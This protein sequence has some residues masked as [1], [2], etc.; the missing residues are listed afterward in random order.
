M[1]STYLLLSYSLITFLAAFFTTFYHL[2]SWS[3]SVNKPYR[4]QNQS[5]RLYPL[6]NNIEIFLSP[7]GNKV[8]KDNLFELIANNFNCIFHH[9]AKGTSRIKSNDSICVDKDYIYDYQHTF[10]KELSLNLIPESYQIYQQDINEL[11]YGLLG[12]FV[13]LLQPIQ[14]QISLKNIGWGVKFNTFGVQVDYAALKNF[15]NLFQK[16]KVKVN[17]QVVLKAKIEIS[18]F[19]AEADELSFRDAKTILT[20][21]KDLGEYGFRNPMIYMEKNSEPL[22]LSFYILLK[23]DKQHKL[24]AEIPN[25]KTNLMSSNFKLSFKYDGVLLPPIR[26]N[27]SSNCTMS[28][29]TVEYKFKDEQEI[30]AIIN[31]K[32]DMISKVITNSVHHFLQENSDIIYQYE[33]QIAELPRFIEQD[34]KIVVSDFIDKQPTDMDHVLWKN[35]LTDLKQSPEFLSFHISSNFCEPYK[36]KNNTVAYSCENPLVPAKPTSKVVKQ[37]AHLPVALNDFDV[38]LSVD[39]ALFN[40]T[41]QA[42]YNMKTFN[43]IE[44]SSDCETKHLNEV[45][46]YQKFLSIDCSDKEKNPF[47]FAIESGDLIDA[48]PNI[49]K[50]NNTKNN[51]TKPIYYYLPNEVETQYT[52]LELRKLYLKFIEFQSLKAKKSKKKKN[53]QKISFTKAPKISFIQEPPD[54]YKMLLLSGIS[55]DPQ[56]IAKLAQDPTRFRINVSVDFFSKGWLQKLFLARKI[57]INMDLIARIQMLP[58]QRD[59]NGT[60]PEGLAL[61]IE[62]VDL[63]S[64]KI[65]S[66]DIRWSGKLISAKTKIKKEFIDANK[67]SLQALLEGKPIR[68][69]DSLPISDSLI[70]IPIN[71]VYI[72]RDLSGRMNL[73]IE[74]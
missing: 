12:P 14:P 60:L 49:I 17:P 57:N 45:P 66:K 19:Y 42:S 43:H 21:N 54:F 62:G 63:D 4:F 7:R 50:P 1:R 28:I 58:K 18:H 39:E 67:K 23:F 46:D 59:C 69:I 61:S 29:N 70:G 32:T 73:Y 40:R 6:R 74:F 71:I 26:C 33:N 55:A 44:L 25:Y 31:R 16:K 37:P 52:T 27:G 20:P 15:Q 13:F 11:F 65:D 9:H 8:L 48:F 56:S 35:S 34:N 10:S 68:L 2:A 38:M 3:V 24:V 5:E 47:C 41:M 30:A 51:N 72:D 36:K 22:Q 53:S 64:I